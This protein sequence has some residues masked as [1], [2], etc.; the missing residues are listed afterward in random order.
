MNG[1]GLN[2]SW[3][4]ST[5]GVDG[6]F[7]APTA[8]QKPITETVPCSNQLPCLI[9]NGRAN[10]GEEC[11]RI[12]LV[13][14]RLQ[15]RRWDWNMEGVS[16]ISLEQCWLL[17]SCSAAWLEQPTLGAVWVCLCPRPKSNKK[18]AG[19]QAWI[20]P[21]LGLQDCKQNLLS[22]FCVPVGCWQL[23]AWLVA[24]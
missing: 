13:C 24:G 10:M 23:W 18:G 20:T 19:V 11:F 3:R 12:Q 8:F 17:R 2:S 4:R 6:S 5:R 15:W 21:R 16:Q 14:P 1:P 7:C 9:V 22:E